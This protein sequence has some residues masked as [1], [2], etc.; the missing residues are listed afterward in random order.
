[1]KVSVASW[2]GSALALA[3]V[4]AVIAGSG[5]TLAQSAPTTKASNQDPPGKALFETV[6]SNCHELNVTTDQR[7]SRADWQ[8]TV[9]KM[10]A[11]GA[12]MTSDQAAQITDYLA[13]T[14]S[15]SSK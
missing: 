12:P 10:I 8:A 11:H 7:K 13:K 3:L 4:S 1:M 14:Y 15:L 6:C 9:D 2:A 5:G